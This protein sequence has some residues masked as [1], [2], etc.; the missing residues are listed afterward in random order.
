ME[1]FALLTKNS[2]RLWVLTVGV[3]EAKPNYNLP[4]T[5]GGGV[6]QGGILSPLLFAIYI[7]DLEDQLRKPKLRSS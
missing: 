1:A 5:L 2:M 7:N 4:I 3:V 6:L